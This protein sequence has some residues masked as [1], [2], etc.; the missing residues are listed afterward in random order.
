[1]RLA[2][3]TGNRLTYLRSQVAKLEIY[4]AVD[5]DTG[6]VNR[7]LSRAIESAL[8]RKEDYLLWRDRPSAQKILMDT[9]IAYLQERY[10]QRCAL[11]KINGLDYKQIPTFQLRDKV[12]LAST[13]GVPTN[14]HP[15]RRII[16]KF[17]SQMTVSC[18]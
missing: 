9:Q 18:R 17:S 4:D 14:S 7:N 13:R 3:C 8:S 10:I 5:R 16:G 2:A 11:D 12:H 6:G 15:L 1:M